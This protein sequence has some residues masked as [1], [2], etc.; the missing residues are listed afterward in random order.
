MGSPRA[1][2]RRK[3]VPSSKKKQAGVCKKQAGV[4]KKQA[5]ESSASSGSGVGAHVQEALL[6]KGSSA[7]AAFYASWDPEFGCADDSDDDE[8]GHVRGGARRERRREREK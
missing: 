8:Y 1:K 6:P 5:G 3:L 2:K 7:L 4:S